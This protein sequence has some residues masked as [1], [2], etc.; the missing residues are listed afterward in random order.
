VSTMDRRAFLKAA[1]GL[2]LLALA[3][4]SRVR[5]LL[6]AAPAVGQPGRFLTAHELDTLRAVA[7][8]LVPGP[9]DDPDPGAVEAGAAEAIDLLL[10]A[11]TLDPPLIHA[12]GPFSDRAGAAH[13]DFAEFVPLD[14]LAELGWRIR[15]EGSKGLPEREFA[16]PVVGLQEVYRRGL[17]HLDQ[18]AGG[19]FATLPGPAQDLILRDQTDGDMQDF[20]GAALPDVLDATY[21]PP[22]YGGNRNLVGWTPNHWPGDTQ[23]RGFTPEQVSQPDPQ[24]T[25]PVLS[26]K[27][28]AAALDFLPAL[29]GEPADRRTP[30]RSR[31]GYRR[32]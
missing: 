15:I 3:P 17:A 5:A 32:G 31:P 14:P 26:A 18:R 27:A 2:G 24:P 21:G 7:G 22:E 11:F 4:P 8:R 20:V 1:G 13:D 25:T 6:A 10:A 30:W 19:A 23:P 29:V 28:A 12:G 9:P 16:G